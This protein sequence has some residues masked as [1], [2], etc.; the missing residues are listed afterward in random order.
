MTTLLPTCSQE[1][2]PGLIWDLGQQLGDLSLE[3]GGLDQE[4]GRSSGEHGGGEGLLGIP[5]F[6]VVSTDPNLSPPPFSSPTL[7]VSWLPPGLQASTR[8]PVP[9]E[10]QILHPRPSAGTVASPDLAP[11]DA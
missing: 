10:A 3:S 11:M 5:S 4:S 2:L 6:P 7:M 9:Q 1:A 8:T